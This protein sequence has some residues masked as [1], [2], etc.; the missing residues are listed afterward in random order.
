LQEERG[1]PDGSSPVA[2]EATLVRAL[3]WTDAFWIASGVPALLV[4]SIGFIALLVGPVSALIWIL[5]VL[6]GLGL[7]FTYAEIAGMF[8]EKSGGPPVFGAQAW[9][10]YFP[11]IAPLNIWAYWFGWSAVQATGVLLM[12]QY[13]Q[14]RWA[15]G[16]T[17]SV[18]WSPTADLGIHVN[19]A[20]VV[21]TAIL[22]GLFWL[23][24][25]GIRQSA[26]TQRVL[27]VTS[28]V[29][30][31]LL[32]VVPIFQGKVDPSLLDP[33]SVPGHVWWSWA[34]FKL[35]CAGLFMAGWSAY[36][37]ET[38]V[39]YTAEFRNPQR[40]APRAIFAAGGLCLFFYGLG[41]FILYAVVGGEQIRED[42]STALVPLA[43]SVFGP[44]GGL[45]IG[46]LLVALLLSVNTAV[47]GC[48]RTLYQASKDGWTFRFL[49]GVS[50]RGV[51]AKAMA[52][53]V[54][55]NLILMLLG[56]VKSIIAAAAIGYM[57]F[58]TLNPVAGHL[59]RKDA[60]GAERPYRAPAAMIRVGVALAAVNL[61]L[62]FVGAPSWGWSSVALGWLIVLAG[63]PIYYYR[64]WRDGRLPARRTAEV[65]PLGADGRW[66]H[67]EPMIAYVVAAG[68]VLTLAVWKDGA[69]AYVLGLTLAAGWALGFFVSRNRRAR[70][71]S[72]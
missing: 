23:N 19:F 15:P 46:L 57:T 55:F 72:W 61:V 60:P 53:A 16:Q 63:I 3:R 11:A 54:G 56:N 42:P 22:V 38:A 26:W 12:G 37:F 69:W 44:A 31:A 35:V 43:G 58:H 70:W 50:R 24:R 65:D 52:F 4:F 64:R 45:L 33:F 39:A 25:F 66:A 2:V 41:P 14:R 10:R 51:P 13:I 18:D 17:W 21:G 6:I 36:G 29:P 49:Q 59:L 28:L 9:K 48:A 62:V 68:G 47:L 67:F 40:D 71:F 34:T 32:F 1:T 20:Y 27:A 30:L 5:S 7:A 8:P